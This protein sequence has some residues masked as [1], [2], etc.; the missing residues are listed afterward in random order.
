MDAS[1]RE[2]L[3]TDWIVMHHAT[4]D[5]E[6]YERHRWADVRL[7]ELVREDPD[8]ALEL[9]L[10]ILARDTSDRVVSNLAAGPVEDLLGEHGDEVIAAVEGIARGNAEFKRLLGGVWQGEMP[11]RV[12][13]RVKAVAATA[14]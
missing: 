1:E 7:S 3:V 10:S 4:E 9:I 12:W 13:E 14:W 8:L 5:S 11:D 6:E 2:R